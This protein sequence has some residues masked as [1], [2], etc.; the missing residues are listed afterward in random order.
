MKTF[1]II[2]LNTDEKLGEV[3]ANNV[4]DAEY[5]ACGIW[6]EVPSQLIAAFTKEQ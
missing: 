5:K 6:P 1:E 2:N 4:I 3:K